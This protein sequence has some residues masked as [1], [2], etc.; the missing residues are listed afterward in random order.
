MKVKGDGYFYQ[1]VY[2]EVIDGFI[3]IGKHFLKLN[4]NDV[5]FFTLCDIEQ[6]NIFLSNIF[7]YIIFHFETTSISK[8]TSIFFSNSSIRIK[9]SL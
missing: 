9:L 8:M 4:I 5:L 6:Y 3:G 2:I 7:F 1:L